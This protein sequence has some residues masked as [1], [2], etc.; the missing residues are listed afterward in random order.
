MS[1]EDERKMQELMFKTFLP[2]QKKEK[3]SKEDKK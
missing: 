1:K 2:P 3:K